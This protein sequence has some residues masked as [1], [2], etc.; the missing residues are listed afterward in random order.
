MLAQ[1]SFT[2]NAWATLLV[3]ADDRENLP[4][5][6]QHQDMVR[7]VGLPILFFD[8]SDVTDMHNWCTHH[9]LHLNANGR[10]AY[11]G[12]LLIALSTDPQGSA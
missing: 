10:A 8:V 11:I 1:A 5:W 12:M 9:G 2:E 6:E 3:E 4:S 7:A